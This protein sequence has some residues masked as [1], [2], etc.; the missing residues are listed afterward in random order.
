MGLM[1]SREI[2]GFLEHDIHYGPPGPVGQIMP[3][4]PAKPPTTGRHWM[5]LWSCC[6]LSDDRWSMPGA[7]KTLTSRD[8]IVSFAPT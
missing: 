4:C 5:F 6:P 1:M 2:F 7:T 8:E 3:F